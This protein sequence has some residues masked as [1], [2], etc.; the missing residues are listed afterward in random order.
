[1][2]FN[3]NFF[4]HFKDHNQAPSSGN[5]QLLSCRNRVSGDYFMICQNICLQNLLQESH[6]IRYKSPN[7]GEREDW[8][9]TCL[10][11]P[12]R[13]EQAPFLSIGQIMTM[14]PEKSVL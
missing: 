4:K 13:Q 14:L 9:F 11:A 1:M 6:I 7:E 10:D 3:M 8:I 2:K 5:T 12:Q